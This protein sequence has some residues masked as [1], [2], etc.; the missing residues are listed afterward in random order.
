MVY[1]EVMDKIFNIH[2]TCY[3]LSIRESELHSLLKTD[4]ALWEK[5]MRRGKGALRA[6]REEK[7]KAKG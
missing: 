3:I 6:E 7:R 5:C 1:E 4:P 2:L